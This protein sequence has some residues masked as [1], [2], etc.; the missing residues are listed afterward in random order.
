ML[1]SMGWLL[2]SAGC[3][4]R[5]ANLAPSASSGSGDNDLKEE[6]GARFSPLRSQPAGDSG[7]ASSQPH[8]IGHLVQYRGSGRT[9]T[10]YYRAQREKEGGSFESI[11]FYFVILSDAESFRWA[12][13]DLQSIGPTSFFPNAMEKEHSARAT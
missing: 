8:N 6:A 11:A 5:N 2:D 9:L 12:P 4:R 3:T 10:A 1:K 13:K 7:E